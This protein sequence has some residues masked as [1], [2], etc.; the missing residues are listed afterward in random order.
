MKPTRGGEG[1]GGGRETGRWQRGEERQ[2]VKT[3]GP[4]KGRCGWQ[5]LTLVTMGFHQRLLMKADCWRT[6]REL[7]E[8]RGGKG[9]WGW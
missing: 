9:G 1:G 3:V 6:V 7:Q 4:L 2:R 8:K 5:P